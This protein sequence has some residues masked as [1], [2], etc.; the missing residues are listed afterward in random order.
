MDQQTL[1]TMWI[2]I[3]TALVFAMQAGFLFLEAGLVRTKNYINVAVKNIVDI[4]LAIMLFWLFGY[5]FMFGDVGNGWWGDGGFAPDIT[6]QG[7]SVVAFFLFQAA[8]AGA[9]VTIISGASAERLKFEGYLFI[10]AVMAFV[11]PIAGHWVWGGGWLA[12]RGFVDFAGSTVVHSMGGWGALATII[13]AG[14]RAGTTAEDGSF[15]PTTPSNLP[16]SIFGVLILWLGWIGFNGGS[17]LAFDDTVAGVIFITMVGGAAGLVGALCWTYFRDGY[18]NPTAPM[19]GVLGGL[20]AVTA[21]AH[22]LTPGAAVIVGGIGGIFAIVAEVWLHKLHIDDAVAAVPVHLGAGAVGTI[23]VGVFGNLE[24]MGTGLG[25]MEQIQTQFIG[26]FAVGLFGFLI[27][28]FALRAFDSFHGLRVSAEHESLGLNE[29]EHRVSSELSDLL[30]DFHATALGSVTATSGR[31]ASSVE[32]LAD[33]S[34]GLA[35]ELTQTA[36][37]AT[38]MKTSLDRSATDARELLDTSERAAITMQNMIRQFEIAV[39][40]AQAADNTS[41]QS[42]AQAREGGEALRQRIIAITRR[43]EDIER[44]VGFIEEIAQKTNLL[45]LNATIESARAGEAGRSFGV[46]ADEVKMLAIDTLDTLA[47]VRR[48]VEGVQTDTS[49]TAE[50]AGKVLAGIVELADSTSDSV[51]RAAELAAEEGER[52]EELAQSFETMASTVRNMAT[53]LETDARRAGDVSDAV[54]AVDELAS[55]MNETSAMMRSDA[56]AALGALS[57]LGEGV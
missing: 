11:Y 56:E 32:G 14:A 6:A 2:L 1:D 13:V 34:S 16:M 12:E 4:G 42:A 8:F 43:S 55:E 38:T 3:C 5:A 25:R 44:L 30:G 54:G 36:A 53:M 49:S 20:V 51:T 18:A 41:S 28:Y 40:A 45:A 9:T 26:V 57:H 7:S 15:R 27:P 23:L 48:T 50:L 29:A 47:E 19:N 35:S 46:V 21:G 24:T 22:A 39:E 37:A 17:V 31:L 33:R 52:V 10:V